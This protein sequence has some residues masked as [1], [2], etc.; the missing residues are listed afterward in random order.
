MENRRVSINIQCFLT[1]KEPQ[2]PTEAENKPTN[3]RNRGFLSLLTCSVLSVCQVV[4]A[5]VVAHVVMAALQRQSPAEP[6][7]GGSSPA[8]AGVGGAR[9]QA[10]VGEGGVCVERV[11]DPGEAGVGLRLAHVARGHT[12]RRVTVAPDFS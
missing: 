10:P 7:G 5:S 3:E 12:V 6:V 8:A 4:Q 2:I 11:E 9:L 1:P